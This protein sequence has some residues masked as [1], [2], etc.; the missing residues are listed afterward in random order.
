VGNT[1]L[2]A[3]IVTGATR[4]RSK[5]VAVRQPEFSPGR[6]PA[7]WL[8]AISEAQRHPLPELRPLDRSHAPEDDSLDSFEDEPDPRAPSAKLRAREQDLR[9]H[10]SE[11]R[12]LVGRLKRERLRKGLSLGDISKLT[13]QARSA[14]SRLENGEY[15]NPTLHTVYRYARALG[16][17]IKL[18]A[19]PVGDEYQTEDGE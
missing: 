6:L 12:S 7:E 1:D 17:R 11:L 5:E 9:A 16:W 19:E 18:C 14:I 8:K 10:E 4:T 13:Q 3:Q 15:T 2:H